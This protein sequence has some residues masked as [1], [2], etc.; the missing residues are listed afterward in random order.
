MGEVHLGYSGMGMC[1]ERLIDRGV[2]SNGVHPTRTLGDFG[3]AEVRC[4]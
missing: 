1:R 4:S 3:G 2:G